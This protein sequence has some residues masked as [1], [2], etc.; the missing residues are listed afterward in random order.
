MK[1][2]FTRRYPSLCRQFMYFR[3][4]PQKRHSQGSGERLS[5]RRTCHSDR[6]ICTI[7]K[8]QKVTFKYLNIRKFKWLFVGQLHYSVIFRLPQQ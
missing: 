3:V 4:W 1:Q 6:A 7:E 8:I 5:S 2:T